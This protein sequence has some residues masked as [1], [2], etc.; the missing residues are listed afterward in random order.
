MNSILTLIM[1]IF[2]RELSAVQGLNKI[3]GTFVFLL[4]YLTFINIIC[5]V[6]LDAV[7]LATTMVLSNPSGNQLAWVQVPP[8]VNNLN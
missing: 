8:G 2:Y 4:I 7:P 3:L 5:F 1:F 6:L